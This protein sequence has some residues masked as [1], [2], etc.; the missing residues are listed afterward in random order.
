MPHSPSQP[1]PFLFPP[2]LLFLFCTPTT[3]VPQVI[4]A[5]KGEFEAGF[6]KGGQTREHAQLVKTAGVTRLIIVINKMD[7][8]T[9]NWDKERFVASPP[10]LRLLLSSPSRWL[11]SSRMGSGRRHLTLES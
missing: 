4:S 7:D 8:P 11:D 10:R 5:R 2:P 6:D 1:S 9:V 3:S